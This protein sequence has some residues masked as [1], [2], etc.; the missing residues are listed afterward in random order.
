MLADYVGFI[1]A[2]NLQICI[3]SSKRRHL[4][5]AKMSHLHCLVYNIQN[6][7]SEH[8]GVTFQNGPGCS[9]PAIWK[10]AQHFKNHRV[11]ANLPPRKCLPPFREELRDILFIFRENIENADVEAQ[12]SVNQI[13]QRT[14]SVD[15]SHN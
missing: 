6:G 14:F 8:R 4:L 15:L 5:F 2:S 9:K 13:N 12:F 11:L 7:F 3:E 10:N 1:L